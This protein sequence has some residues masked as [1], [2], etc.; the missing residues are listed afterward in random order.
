MERNQNSDAIGQPPERIP[1]WISIDKT[2]L[3]DHLLYTQGRLPETG[4]RNDWYMALAH[5]MRDSPDRFRSLLKWQAELFRPIVDSL[6]DRDEYLL[7]ANYQS[8]LDQ[9]DQAIH[10]FSDR[11][12]WTSMSILNVAR[13]GY[14]S[15]DRSIQ[16]YCDR[17]WHTKPVKVEIS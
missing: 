5:T 8:Y 16:E 2:D 9:Q 12:R 17:N 6:L 4:T 11:D 7:F 14:F 13:A 10:A 3:L 1:T 15:S